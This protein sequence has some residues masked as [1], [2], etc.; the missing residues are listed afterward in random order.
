MSTVA[1]IISD[2]R[3]EVNDPDSTRFSDIAV[4][5]I[6][7]QAIRRANRICQRQQLHFAKKSVALATV[8]TQAYVTM[9][10]DLDVPIAL[11][12]DDLHTKIAQVTENDWEQLTEVGEISSWFLDL[13]N[14]RILLNATPQSVINLTFW[15]FPS[16]DPSA[17][18]IASTMPWSGRIDDVI[19]Q[20]VSMR[21]QN[22]EEMNIA[23]NQ[24]ILSE[25]EA[26]IVSVYAPQSPQIIGMKGPF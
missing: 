21:L 6:V 8:A 7:K 24:A 25:M 14:S 5:A 15:Y 13:Q 26:S 2:V 10:V 20:Y 12:R 19:V 18:T 1:E 16:L 23:Q 4:L 11:Y 17:Y 9:P 3:V 22:I